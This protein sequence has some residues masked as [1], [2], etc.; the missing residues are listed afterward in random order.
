MESALT[1]GKRKRDSEFSAV[2]CIIC[3]EKRGDDLTRDATTKG[4]S[5]LRDALTLRT[6]FNCE[7]YSDAINKLNKNQ[8]IIDDASVRLV[9]HK[10][11]FSSFTSKDHLDRLKKR[12]EK[13]QKPAY[14]LNSEK[15]KEGTSAGFVSR[16]A[17]P[18]VK[19]GD[20]H[21]LSGGSHWRSETGVNSRNIR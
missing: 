10:G 11:C 9:Y 2:K 1:I 13:V 12:Y 4:L 7:K 17:I 15:E 14:S 16:R 8:H 6:R 3:Q 20:V 5:T 21:L 19:L 18:P